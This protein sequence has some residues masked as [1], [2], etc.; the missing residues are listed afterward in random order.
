MKEVFGIDLGTTNSCIA[1]IGE[2]GLPKVIK[3]LDDEFTTPSVVYYDEEGEIY[4]G[5]EAKSGMGGAP[6]RTVA[7]IKREMSNKE[8]KRCIGDM[9]VSPVEVSAIILKKVVDDANEQRSYEGLPPIK[10]AVITVPA[11]FGNMER[12]LTKQAGKI[13]GLEVLDL[14]NEPTA[15]ALS[16]GTKGLEGKTFMI[17]DLGGGT[18]D[19][20]I[21]RMKNGVLDTLSTDGD[22]KLGGVDWDI[23]LLDYALQTSGLD[24]TYDDIKEEKDAAKM[25]YN[26]EIC[27]KNLSKSD[28]ASI[29][30]IYKR[31]QYVKDVSRSLFEEITEDLLE[32][33]IDMIHH[34][35]KIAREPLTVSDIDE[36]ILVGGSSYMPMVKKRLQ[37]EFNCNI[38]LDNLEPDRAIAQGAALH[39]ARL[40]GE[41]NVNVVLGDDMGSR[42][43]GIKCYN[44][45]N[46][47]VV[48][49]II[50]RTD[51][52][53]YEDTREFYTREEGQECVSIGIYENTSIEDSI[54]VSKSVLVEEKNLNW[55][56]P[57]PKDTVV[58]LHVSRGKDGIIHVWGE[59]QNQE[60]SFEI[61]P[62]GL[63]SEEEAERL[64]NELSQKRV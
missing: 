20:S 14:L 60:V 40:S 26:A 6:E 43:Y 10:E 23:A 47:L 54:A 5:K 28:K 36:I 37:K 63:F 52:L 9:E 18:F 50:K 44:G 53:E 8:Y 55:G 22:H 59:C 64:K 61:K 11:Y 56:F 3:N 48:E 24:V 38:K 32:N 1:V 17:Y 19:I 35:I 42:S 51:S 29:K 49:N 33:T 12:E 46:K 2:D 39:A 57:V 4:A 34:A 21:M 16:Y 41:E 31:K 58:T 15:A 30:L 62:E 27:K 45:D 13:A 7:F 25:L